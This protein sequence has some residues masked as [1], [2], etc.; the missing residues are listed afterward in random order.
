MLERLSRAGSVR[1]LTVYVREAFDIFRSALVDLNCGRVSLEKLVVTSRV[2]HEL[3]DYRSPTPAARAA[4]Q[5]F[6]QTGKRARPGQKM[7][8]IFTCGEPD[9]RPWELPGKIDPAAVDRV[10]YTEL[11]ARAAAS[12]F[13]PFGIDDAQLKQWAHTRSI[14][15]DLNLSRDVNHV[16]K[17][18]N[19]A[20]GG[21][22]AGAA[23]IGR[24]AR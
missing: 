4:L 10:K 24:A 13:H 5:L 22:F 2:S 1:D 19:H 11:L 23:G 14:A 12:I 3:E 7:R 16:W 8:F 6:E 21:R 15:L 9:V 17:I 20:P 18:Y